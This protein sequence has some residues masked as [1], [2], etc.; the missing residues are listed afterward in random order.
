MEP[1]EHSRPGCHFNHAVQ[2]KT[3]ERDGPLDQFGDDGDET[4]DAVVGDGEVFEPLAPSN[5]FT[6]VWRDGSWHDYLR[7]CSLFS[8]SLLESPLLFFLCSGVRFFA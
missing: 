1:P 2:A 6:A 7:L 5:Q 8:G 4:F 3:D